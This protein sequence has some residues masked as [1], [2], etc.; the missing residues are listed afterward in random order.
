VLSQR[1]N[2]QLICA[3][4][5]FLSGCVKVRTVKFEPVRREIVSTRTRHVPTDSR[6]YE[7]ELSGAV[8]A[9]G[10]LS[11]RVFQI[12]QCRVVESTRTRIVG[13]VTRE[14]NRSAEL[15]P[16]A[17]GIMGG[18]GALYAVDDAASNA[19]RSVAGAALLLGVGMVGQFVYQ[20]IQSV[21]GIS[22]RLEGDVRALC[23]RAERH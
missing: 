7:V 20:W 19:E 15:Q 3:F 22:T 9:D 11:G 17:G 12:S 6:Y 16:I 14:L 18:L 21:D 8:S 13:E 1:V 5:A 2:A 23:R 4:V 10:L